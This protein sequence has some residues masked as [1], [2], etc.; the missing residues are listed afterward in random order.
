M[1]RLQLET[2]HVSDG[3]LQL[4]LPEVDVLQPLAQPLSNLGSTV[5]YSTVQHSTVQCLHHLVLG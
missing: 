2:H 5:H 4:E 3:F 1:D